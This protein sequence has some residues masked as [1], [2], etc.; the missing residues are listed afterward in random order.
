MQIIPIRASRPALAPVP[1]LFPPT[2]DEMLDERRHACREAV[3]ATD[4]ERMMRFLRLVDRYTVRID[5]MV[6]S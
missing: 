3:R 4:D 1:Q 2:L 6:R 5:R